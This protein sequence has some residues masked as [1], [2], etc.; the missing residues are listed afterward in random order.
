MILESLT[1]LKAVIFIL[2]NW[3]LIVS[4]LAALAV[5]FGAA[6]FIQGVRVNMKEAELQ[7]KKAELQQKKVEIAS[8]KK[9]LKDCQ[10]ANATNQETIG[11]L[12]DEVE[13]AQKLCNSRLGVKDKVINRLKE[14]DN[15]TKPFGAHKAPDTVALTDSGRSGSEHVE[16]HPESALYK[17]EVDNEKGIDAVDDDPI[18]HELNRMFINKA[19]SKD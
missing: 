9:D 16:G 12:K 11:K 10:D 17:N 4:F 15:I 2:K 18:L 13:S 19:D 14:I 3:K 8:L 1:S 7:K 5:G 6:W